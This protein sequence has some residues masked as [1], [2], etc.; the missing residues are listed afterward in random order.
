MAG[1]RVHHL[2]CATI[3][4]LSIQGRHLICHCLVVET[5]GSGLVLVDTGLGSADHA[6]VSSRLGVAFARGYGRPR[7]EPALAAIAQLRVAGLEP[8]D[9]RHVVLT[10]LDLDHVGGLSDFPEATVHVH[11]AELAAATERRG[12][13]ARWRYRPPM[14]AHGPRFVTYAEAGERWFGFDAVGT[15]HGL[16]DD[17]LLVPLFGHTRGHSGVALR[18]DAGWLLHAGDAYYDP[19]EVHG[20][21]RRCSPGVWAFEAIVTTNRKQRVANQDRLRQ[22]VG[23]HPEVSVFSAHDPRALP[24]RFGIDLPRPAR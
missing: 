20:P 1:L 12:V 24:E 22:L 11:A 19:R 5:P 9:V 18:T 7:R 10:H 21:V 17:L 6:D 13:K 4:G 14:W 15:L 16:P 23:E 2:N 8:S 3:Q